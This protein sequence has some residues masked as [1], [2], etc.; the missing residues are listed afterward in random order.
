[1]P[2]E[3]FSKEVEEPILGKI[4]TV[5]EYVTE[6]GRVFTDKFQ[7]DQYS[8]GLEASRFSISVEQQIY[9]EKGWISER[10]QTLSDW[11]N[12]VVEEV[13]V[14]YGSKEIALPLWKDL[15]GL[16]KSDNSVSP[17]EKLRKLAAADPAGM[18]DLVAKSIPL[19]AREAAEGIK[20][21]E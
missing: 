16:D 17:G 7:A 11:I 13:S 15:G 3:Y 8:R 12:G 6:D 2:E 21:E 10:V 19:Y 20:E 18:Y 14:F 9:G 5:S 4:R 1:M